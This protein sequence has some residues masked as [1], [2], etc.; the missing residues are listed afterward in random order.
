M[1][2]SFVFVSF[3]MFMLT[4]TSIV[5]A[6]MV[7]LPTTEVN[8]KKS[9]FSQPI[10]R[11]ADFACP[12]RQRGRESTEF[13]IPDKSEPLLTEQQY[14]DM[15]QGQTQRPFCLQIGNQASA[16]MLA[17]VKLNEIKKVQDLLEKYGPNDQRSLGEILNGL[18]LE[19][20]G[21]IPPYIYA[22]HFFDIGTYGS[23]FIDGYYG[24]PPSELAAAL[25][26]GK[27]LEAL[28]Q[29]R[30]KDFPRNFKEILERKTLLEESEYKELLDVIMRRDSLL[31]GCTEKICKAVINFLLLNLHSKETIHNL[32]YN[33]FYPEDQK[34]K[35]EVRKM[36]GE[37]YNKWKRFSSCVS[38]RE[39]APKQLLDEKFINELKR[40]TD[41]I[42]PSQITMYEVRDSRLSYC[43]NWDGMNNT[44]IDTYG[45]W[46]DDMLT[47]NQSLMY[48]LKDQNAIHRYMVKN[49][50]SPRQMADLFVHDLYVAR[51]RCATHLAEE[52]NKRLMALLTDR[53]SWVMVFLNKKATPVNQEVFPRQMAH[54]MFEGY[55]ASH[56]DQPISE[57][58]RVNKPMEVLF[59]E[60]KKV[61]A[62]N[63]SMAFTGTHKTD[64]SKSP[65]SF[66]E[67]TDMTRAKTT[68]L[69]Q[70][71]ISNISAFFNTYATD[72]GWQ[73]Y[74]P[75][76]TFSNTCFFNSSM[77]FFVRNNVHNGVSWIRS[78]IKENIRGFSTNLNMEAIGQ[79]ML[80]N[81]FAVSFADTLFGM[82]VININSEKNS[83]DPINNTIFYGPMVGIVIQGKHWRYLRYNPELDR[84]RQKVDSLW[85][86]GMNHT[87]Y[88][89]TRDSA[90][91]RF[92]FDKPEIKEAHA[93]FPLRRTLELTEE[94]KK[95]GTEEVK[96]PATPAPKRHAFAFFMRKTKKKAKIAA[97]Y[98]RAWWEPQRNGLDSD[99]LGISYSGDTIYEYEKMKP[100]SFKFPELPPLTSSQQPTSTQESSE[101]T[102]K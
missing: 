59:D 18:F 5:D 70:S 51:N 19:M 44:R 6:M 78:L 47:D 81:N 93:T 1:K 57:S 27:K 60:A 24:K 9:I 55:V 71:A 32:V 89:F 2:K 38:T 35:E 36:A 72:F 20:A 30:S 16:Q 29:I 62:R 10:D 75:T 67:M 49:K 48:R 84:E 102:K 91:R 68:P 82:N 25:G 86:T 50:L 13:Y 40:I 52:I 79:V 17:S 69:M 43:F 74:Y 12:V 85:I 54:L 15:F 96:T 83:I 46:F 26:I 95:I 92:F 66:N 34:N 33:V 11:C 73:M 3:T 88:D 58:I 80:G 7:P 90:D 56:A 39:Y 37:K 28:Y 4:T 101:P 94:E 21:E 65:I 22:S 53:R 41:P 76:E 98:Q 8:Y 77:P 45:Q 14:T 61:V 87:I 64:L 23:R 99:N 42:D 63:V 31:Y 100:L 97:K